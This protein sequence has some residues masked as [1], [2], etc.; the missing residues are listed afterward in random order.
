MLNPIGSQCS[1]SPRGRE[2][3]TGGAGSRRKGASER[4]GSGASRWEQR[5]PEA[6]GPA[7]V[8][9]RP[10]RCS[11]PRPGGFLR[12]RAALPFVGLSGAALTPDPALDLPMR[13]RARPGFPLE[14]SVR[15]RFP[16]AG[17][18]RELAEP[19]DRAEEPARLPPQ[20]TEP[21]EGGGSER[22][23]A[24]V[25]GLHGGRCRGAGIERGLET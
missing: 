16:F 23:P 15:M 1:A 14:L 3:R 19:A 7:A 12:L 25:G 21:A 20:E 17:S 10:W 6:P 5:M 4:R 22:T 2:G 24:G 13:N 18:V 11:D 9:S 8:E